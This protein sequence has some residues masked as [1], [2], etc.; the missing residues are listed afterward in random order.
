[1]RMRTDA[2]FRSGT[3]LDSI[4]A[5]SV[6]NTGV[7]GWRE[8]ESSERTYVFGRLGRQ[9]ILKYSRC[10]WGQPDSKQSSKH[11]CKEQAPNCK[12]TLKH[13]VSVVTRLRHG[14]EIG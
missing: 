2:A 1:M 4:G 6:F 3:C 14:G 9:S 7:H 5:H 11:A 12:L 13:F 10:A 8:N